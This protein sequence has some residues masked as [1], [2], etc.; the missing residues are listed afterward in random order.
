[1][2]LTSHQIANASANAWPTLF[3]GGSS[4]TS[5]WTKGGFQ[6]FDAISAFTSHTKRAIRPH[7]NTA[8]AIVA[9]IHDAYRA[10]WYGRPGPAFV[11]LPTDLIMTPVSSTSNARRPPPI[12]PPR[13]Q[14]GPDTIDEA[15]KLLKTARAP[16]VIIGKGAAYAQAEAAIRALVDANNLPFLPTPMGKGVVPDSHPLNVSS[17]RS[18]ALREADV[19]LLLGARLNWILHMAAAPKY[20]KD[21]KIIQV[22]ISPEELGRSNS[23]NQPGLSIFAD[24]GRVVE[25]L[26]RALSGWQYF[27]A[28]SIGSALS[29]TPAYFRKLEAGATKNER[30]AARLANTKTATGQ[31]LTFERAFHIIKE[32][33]HTLSPPE[34]DGIVYIGEGSQ[35][36]DISRSI[37][38]LNAPRQKLDAGTY[39]TMGVGLAY[40]TAAWAAYNLP[41]KTKKIVALEGDSAF[42]F[43]AMEVET[44]RR[45]E[46]DVLIL[47]M[48]NSGVYSG[49]SADRE[50][51]FAK[52]KRL[53]HGGGSSGRRDRLKSSSLMHETRYEQ[54]ADLCG[55]KGYFVRT[56]EELE[57]ATR[58]GYQEDRITVVNVIIE[59]GNDKNISFA[60]MDAKAKAKM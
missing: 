18:V 27:P 2:W 30:Q 34:K 14:A 36:M 40:C 50:D 4:E 44:M 33:L 12:H 49:D 11:D 39:A 3:L 38:P 48:N 31:P 32:A 45:H 17:A 55:G 20:K 41:N 47:V 29:S 25:Q 28:T 9:A 21:V 16:L 54:L 52:Q 26:N 53:L 8:D 23:D 51:W 15:V 57:R 22:D 24:V 10:C 13:P 5:L 59:P 35:T 42:G 19:V 60:W 43:A 58:E 56:E 46:M 1:M 37:F 7:K 6:E